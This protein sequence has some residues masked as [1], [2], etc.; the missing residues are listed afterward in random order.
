[1][2]RFPARSARLLGRV[3]LED[4]LQMLVLLTVAN[5]RTQRTESLTEASGPPDALRIT[6]RLSKHLGRAESIAPTRRRWAGGRIAALELDAAGGDGVSSATA[7]IGSSASWAV[8]RT[9][10]TG[11]SGFWAAARDVWPK[12]REQQLTGTR[13][14]NAVPSHAVRTLRREGRTDSGGVA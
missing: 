4:A 3:I 9:R 10:Q 7:S 1:V 5:R 12:T 2:N 8:S 13:G 14:S 11:R 6:L